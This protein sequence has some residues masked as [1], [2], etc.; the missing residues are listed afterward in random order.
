[1]TDGSLT[2]T[3]ALAYLRELSLD[4]RAAVVFDAAGQRLAGDAELVER[5]R[6]ALPTSASAEPGP[7]VVNSA[8]ETLVIGRAASG[9]AIAVAAGPYALLP[10][11]IH[12]LGTVLRNIA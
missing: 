9:I 10:L 5:A 3:L 4:V 12:D 7:W 1:M 11:L 2:P 8:A 6:A